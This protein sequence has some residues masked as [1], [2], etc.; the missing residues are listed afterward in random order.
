[1]LKQHQIKQTK[2]KEE[3]EHR[4]KETIA[5]VTNVTNAL[6]NSVNTGVAHIHA[7]QRKLEHETRVLQQ[8]TQ[9]FS[10]QTAQ[11]LKLIDNFNTSLKEVGDIENWAKSIET[12]MKAIAGALEYIQKPLNG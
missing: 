12:D 4:R 7:N 11:W 9:R 6:V 8:Q 5:S 1:L 10:K 3:T 2:L